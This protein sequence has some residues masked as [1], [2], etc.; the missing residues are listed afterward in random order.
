ML[1]KFRLFKYVCIFLF[2]LLI[3]NG[4]AVALVGAIGGA[5]VYAIDETPANHKLSNVNMPDVQAPDVYPP[6]KDKEKQQNPQVDLTQVPTILPLDATQDQPVPAQAAS[7][8][9]QLELF[10]ED[11]HTTESS[12]TLTHHVI[13]NTSIDNL[14]GHAWKVIGQRD[15]KAFSFKSENSVFNFSKRGVFEAF[16]SCNVIY[17]KMQI[18]NAG[19]FFLS[20]LHSSNDLCSGGRDQ[21]VGIINQLILTNKFAIYDKTMILSVDDMPVLA[22]NFTDQKID[23]AISHEYRKVRRHQKLKTRKGI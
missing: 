7:K 2:V 1:I 4:C 6:K 10:K 15:V 20:N 16:I 23:S 9:A 19:K 8:L 13:N 22:F 14:T 5:G 18:D 21:E 11:P 17:G 3:L 12:K